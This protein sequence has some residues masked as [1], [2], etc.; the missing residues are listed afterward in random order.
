MTQL[1]NE[2]FSFTCNASTFNYLEKVGTFD[3]ANPIEVRDNAA[4]STSFGVNGFNPSSLLS[5]NYH[6]PYLHRGQAQTLEAVFPLHGLGAEWDGIPADNHDSDRAD[7]AAAGESTGVP[8]VYRWHHQPSPLRGGCVQGYPETTG[9]PLSYA[10]TRLKHR[11][12]G[13]YCGDSAL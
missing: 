2:L 3:I 9:S 4:A 5:I 7:R 8:E 6:A 11:R 13:T 1:A 10:V 12:R